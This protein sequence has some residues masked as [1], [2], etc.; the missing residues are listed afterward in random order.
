[1][2]LALV[3]RYGVSFELVAELVMK[4]DLIR[5]PICSKQGYERGFVVARKLRY[6][7]GGGWSF[8]EETR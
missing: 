6:E 1:M 7:S 2:Q 4:L 5:L 3:I 8:H